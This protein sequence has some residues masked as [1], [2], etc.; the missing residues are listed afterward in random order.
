MHERKGIMQQ[1]DQR[2]T[3]NTRL[4]AK[5]LSMLN[6]AAAAALHRTAEL[7]SEIKQALANGLTTDEVRDILNEVAIHADSSVA[8]CVRIAEQALTDPQQ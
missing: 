1:D 4:S 6:I 5:D 8:D 7:R 2:P 3:H